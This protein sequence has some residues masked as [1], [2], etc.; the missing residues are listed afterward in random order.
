MF[1][2]RCVHPPGGATALIA[3]IGGDPVHTLGFGYVLTPVLLNVASL[4]TVAFL[5]NALFPWRRYPAAWMAEPPVDAP[6]PAVTLNHDDLHHALQEIGWLVDITET[7]LQTLL[8]L[9]TAHAT[10]RQVDGIR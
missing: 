4:I 10:A 8:A 1:Q 7:D 3:V 2:C 5:F 9:A 6:V